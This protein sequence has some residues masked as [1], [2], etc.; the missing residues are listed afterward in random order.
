MRAAAIYGMGSILARTARRTRRGD[1][2][3]LRSY[4][5]ES[6][7]TG[8]EDDARKEMMALT[9]E[10]HLSATHAG[11]RRGTVTRVLAGPARQ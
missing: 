9:R 11:R 4:G 6:A 7:W 1:V 10:P 8:E 3:L 5:A 2:E